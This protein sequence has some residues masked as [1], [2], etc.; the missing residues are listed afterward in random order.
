MA[1]LKFIQRAKTLGFT[2][3]DI[4]ELLSLSDDKK[5]DMS[6]V[7]QAAQ[8]RLVSVDAKLV[9][10][11]RLREGLLTLISACPGHGALQSCPILNA[12]G[13]SSHEHV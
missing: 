4:S 9:E 5:S 3:A 13:D 10:L 11:T 1:R 2:L 12:P 7:K 8:A 6:L